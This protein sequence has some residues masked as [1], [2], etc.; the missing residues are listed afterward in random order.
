MQQGQTNPLPGQL[1]SEATF[2][3]PALEQRVAAVGLRLADGPQLG[4]SLS[5]LVGLTLAPHLQYQRALQLGAEAVRVHVFAQARPVLL[6]E[7]A[8]EP[9]VLQ[10]AGGGQ[11]AVGAEELL[12]FL[13]R[14]AVHPLAQGLMQQVGI[15]RIISQSPFQTVEAGLVAAG[16]G[17]LGLV[18]LAALFAQ[19]VCM[20][21]LAG[22][23]QSRAEYSGGTGQV[24]CQSLQH[25][26]PGVGGVRP[27]Y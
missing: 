6:A 21:S 27:C 14:G 1:R 3:P 11:V 8:F 26:Y 9:G 12:D 24:S 15:Q 18:V 22:Q 19:P 23:Q 2:G 16:K 20:N 4:G 10:A 25:D 7:Q 13:M 17:G 5:G